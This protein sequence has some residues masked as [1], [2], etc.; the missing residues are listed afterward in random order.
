MCNEFSF[1]DCLDN[2]VIWVGYS[3]IF[4][5]NVYLES[6]IINVQNMLNV[7]QGSVKV[8]LEFGMLDFNDIVVQFFDVVI[9]IC[10]VIQQFLE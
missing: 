2:N 1:L 8:L 3:I 5:W 4:N 10:F 9:Y 7:C 6:V